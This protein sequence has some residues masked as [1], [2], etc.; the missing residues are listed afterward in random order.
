MKRKHEEIDE[1]IHEL[2]SKEEAEFYEKLEEEQSIYEQVT[3][4]FKG[5]YK[6][7]A[8]ASTIASLV[9]MGVCVYSAMRFFDATV[10]KE[11]L[12]WLGVFLFSGIVIITNK[13]LHWTQIS[14][15]TI[16]R[17]TKR[18][19]LQLAVLVKSINDAKEK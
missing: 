6:I 9:A 17:E 18:L 8:I 5:A 15:N 3:G 1:L 4:L 7:P 16:Q 10:T 13:I 2:L 14:V 19:E 12:T 11:L